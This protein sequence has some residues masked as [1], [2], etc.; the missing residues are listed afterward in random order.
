MVSLAVYLRIIVPLYRQPQQPYTASGTS[1][2]IVSGL[3]LTLTLVIGIAAQFIISLRD[4]MQGIGTS[5]DARRSMFAG[6]PK[7]AQR[8]N[9]TGMRQER[10]IA[11]VVLPMNKVR[12]RECP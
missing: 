1:F 12:T 4:I 2:I 8:N 10:S 3:A 7:P 9:T 11:L 6:S 5:S